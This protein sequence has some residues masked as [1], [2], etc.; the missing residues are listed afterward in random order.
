MR[1]VV[2]PLAAAMHCFG[3]KQYTSCATAMAGLM[4]VLHRLGGSAAL[5]HSLY[6]VYFEW[7]DDAM[8]WCFF[9][10]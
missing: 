1:G 6:A 2:E 9:V 4:P 7:Y 8:F 10:F 5:R 3:L